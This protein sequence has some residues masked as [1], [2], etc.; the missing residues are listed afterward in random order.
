M[1]PVQA[2]FLTSLFG[3]VVSLVAAVGVARL[4][5][6]RDVAPFGRRTDSVK[7]L[8]RPASYAAASAAGS[9]RTLAGIGYGLLGVAILCLLYQFF[10]DAARALG[11]KP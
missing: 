11:P 9:I 7:V 1:S 10:A 8:A 2:I 3:G 5:W 4:N 6:R